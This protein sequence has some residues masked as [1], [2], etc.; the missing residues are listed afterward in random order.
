MSLAALLCALGAAWVALD[1]PTQTAA[2]PPEAAAPPPQRPPPLAAPSPQPTPLR[3]E[4]L[5]DPQRPWPD[6]KRKTLLT[7]VHLTD[8]HVGNGRDHVAFARAVEAINALSPPPAFVIITGDLT[9][10]FTPPQVRQFQQI[11]GRL[12]APVHVVP[13]N[14]DVTFDPNPARLARWRASFPNDQTPYRV[15]YGPLALVGVDSQLWNLRHVHPDTQAEA[16]RQWAR[17]EDLIA[18]A[19]REGQRVLVFHHIPALPAFFRKKVVGSWR[20]PEMNR[21]RALLREHQVEAELTGHFH[22]DELY[23]SDETLL[24]NAPPI[25]QKYSRQASFR[26]FRVTEAGLMVRQIYLGDPDASYEVDL[27]GLNLARWRAWLE[28]LDDAG[29]RALWRR[30]YTDEPGA[31]RH[32]Q[33]VDL[34]RL[35]AYHLDPFSFQPQRGRAST[36]ARGSAMIPQDA[37]ADEDEDTPE[38]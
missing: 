17:A 19:R 4:P 29:W 8:T 32:F 22:R 20:E 24:L 25:C 16:R 26:L 2:P 38:W 30:R 11:A 35:R 7:F 9:E 6:D 13:G 23:M 5:P 10:S 33:E 27:H 37:S 18:A 14:H 3:F 1:A 15:D 31:P 28:G 34:A 12:R 21:W 36:S